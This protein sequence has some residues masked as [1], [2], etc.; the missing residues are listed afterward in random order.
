MGILMDAPF[1]LLSGIVCCYRGQFRLTWSA[2][3]R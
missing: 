3:L 1:L 2:I